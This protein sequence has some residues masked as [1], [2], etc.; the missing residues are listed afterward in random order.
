MTLFVFILPQILESKGERH[1]CDSCFIGA[2]RPVL[3]SWEMT[4]MESEPGLQI[5]NFIPFLQHH[6]ILG[7]ED[8]LR[9]AQIFHFQ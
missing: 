2:A 9:A 8:G 3:P 4:G 5:P 6:A 1:F 7:R